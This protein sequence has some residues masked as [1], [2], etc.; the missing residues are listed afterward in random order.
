MAHRRAAAATPLLA[1][2]LGGEDGVRVDSADLTVALAALAERH[3]KDRT[4]PSALV[5]RALK[6]CRKVAYALPSV[7]SDDRT[8]A[9]VHHG[10]DHCETIV[11]VIWRALNKSVPPG[12]DERVVRH[13]ILR[14]MRSSV[15]AKKADASVEPDRMALRLAKRELTQMAGKR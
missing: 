10:F 11:S 1:D 15:E 2:H 8:L 7:A 13:L 5:E 14:H 3:P 9:L 4:S 6:E 12:A